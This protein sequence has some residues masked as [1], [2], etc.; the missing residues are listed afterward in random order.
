M[1]VPDTVYCPFCGKPMPSRAVFCPHCGQQA[2][3]LEA[4]VTPTAYA[5]PPGPQFSVAPP[6]GAHAYCRACANA[7]DPR[8]VVCPRCGVPTA[9]V[10]TA[11]PVVTFNGVAQKSVGLAIFLDILFPGAGTAY[12]GFTKRAMPFLIANCVG[13]FFAFTA[14]LFFISVIIWLVTVLMVAPKVADLARFAN[15]EIARTG[16]APHD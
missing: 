5:P 10:P 4:P 14:I 9:A 11:V 6:V 13:V 15:A 2:P 3:R 12:V 1:A 8:A 7:I 16:Q